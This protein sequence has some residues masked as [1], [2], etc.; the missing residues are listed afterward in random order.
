MSEPISGTQREPIKANPGVVAETLLALSVHDTLCELARVRGA[1]GPACDAIS[2]QSVSNQCPISGNQCP[3]VSISGNQWQSVVI[4][5]TQLQSVH[6]EH[7]ASSDNQC[8]SSV[9]IISANHQYQSSVPIILGASL[10][11]TI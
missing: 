3:S 7:D 11:L 1:V 10:R 8:Q 6:G 4:G 2:V 5:C 9:P